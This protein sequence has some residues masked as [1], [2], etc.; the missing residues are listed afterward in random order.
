[1]DG[2]D[3]LQE[4]T[5]T[6]SSILAWEI[7]R[8]EEPGGLQSE[9]HKESDTTERVW[10]WRPCSPAAALGAPVL[11]G[12]RP[13]GATG[14]VC[15]LETPGAWGKPLG[16]PP[17]GT[18]ESGADA[19]EAAVAPAWVPR[20]GLSRQPR[21]PAVAWHRVR[22]AAVQ[23]SLGGSQDGR[24]GSPVGPSSPTPAGVPASLNREVNRV[25][26]LGAACDFPACELRSRR[27]CEQ[28]RGVSGLRPPPAPPRPR[29]E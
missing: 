7:P 10:A 28:G 22:T 21:G 20:V 19:E 29:R 9:D 13:L 1:M 8:T 11:L 16:P 25:L 2:G 12:M 14:G 4:E 18:T 6:P 24:P 5:A 15:L 3:P 27:A 23:P 26:G 17:S